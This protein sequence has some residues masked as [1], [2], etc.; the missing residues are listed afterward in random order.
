[1]FEI[2]LKIPAGEYCNGC[3]F[4]KKDVD[5]DRV[6]GYRTHC[7]LFKATVSEECIKNTQE[8]GKIYKCSSCPRE[9]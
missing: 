7:L 6:S 8:I 3:M 9:G 2:T 5:F 1:M 4:V